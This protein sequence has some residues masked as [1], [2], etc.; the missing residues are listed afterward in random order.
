M[1]PFEQIANPRLRRLRPTAGSEAGVRPIDESGQKGALSNAM[2]RS[3]LCVERR[4]CSSPR[5]SSSTVSGAGLNHCNGF[6]LTGV[7]T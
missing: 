3:A 1:L 6:S 7:A 4:S 5:S 2:K